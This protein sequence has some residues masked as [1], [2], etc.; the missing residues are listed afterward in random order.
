MSGGG[1][2]SVPGTFPEQESEAFRVPDLYVRNEERELD[3]GLFVDLAAILAGGVPDG[4]EPAV[5]PR[6]DGV[7]LFYVGQVNVVFGDPESGKTWLALAAVVSALQ[8]GAL[9][10]VVDLDHN[11]PEGTLS[12]LLAL[13]A[14]PEVL[15]D[16]SRFR[17]VEP[18]DERHLAEVVAALR[19]W[20]PGVVVVDSIG[21][22]LPMMRL[23][24]NQPDDFTV[25]HTRALKPLAT[26][27]AAVIGIDHLAKNPDSAKAGPTGTAAKRR[28][29]GGVSLRVK[30]QRAFTPGSG[31]AAA[32][33]IHKDRHGG[34]RQ[35]CPPP[36][37]SEPYAG[38]FVLT[39]LGNARLGW[40]V[41][42]PALADPIPGPTGDAAEVARLDPP[43]QSVNDVKQRLGWGS[44]RASAALRF[45]RSDPAFRVPDIGGRNEERACTGCGQPLHQVHRDAGFDTCPTCEQ[46]TG[47]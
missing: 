28:A 42:P 31:G 44:D 19:R 37:G 39:D 12:R 5:C 43:P 29:V 13:G 16:R 38:Q 7:S 17:Y 18:E 47:S 2:M 26:A 23:S 33:T 21:E 45:W 35:H 1:V 9:C 40:K 41:V 6:E 24:S 46:G 34:L 10:A 4:P 11:G 36:D 3:E 20:R 25:G 8:A 30:V 32:L 15:G 14:V 22:L 27:G